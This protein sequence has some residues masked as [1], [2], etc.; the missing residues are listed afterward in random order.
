MTRKGPKGRSPS[1]QKATGES[2]PSR[3]VVDMFPDHSSKPDPD[4]LPPPAGLLS[5]GKKVWGE[6]VERYRR[7]GQK[8]DGFQSSLKQYVQL[9][10]ELDSLRKMKIIPSASLIAQHRAYAA[11]FYDTP[12]SQRLKLSGSG[13]K[14]N[15]FSQ[16]GKPPG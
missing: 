8:V 9:E 3:K 2:R 6:K 11:E 7:R 16:F 4:D 15:R 5:A 14:P 12:A 1:Q 10:V 13:D